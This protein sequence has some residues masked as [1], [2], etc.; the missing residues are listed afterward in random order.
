M[1][2]LKVGILEY[3]CGNIRSILS[4]IKFLGVKEI[5]LAKSDQDIFSCDCLILPGVGAFGYAIDKI[6]KNKL[7]VPIR[8]FVE[9]GGFILGIC[10]GMQL[11]FEISYEM[12][13][14]EGLGLI[15]GKIIKLKQSN[16][17]KCKLPNIGWNNITVQKNIY[18]PNNIIYRKDLDYLYF[19]HSYAALPSYKKNIIATSQFYDISFAAVVQ[20]NNIYGCQ[21]HPEKSGESGLKILHNFLKVVISK[22]RLA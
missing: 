19:V 4:A 15:P 6:N 20:K 3:G 21:F 12:G 9:K 18:Q 16:L 11:L 1:I 14:H 7:S 22:K 13:N 5:I 17:D 2:N 10:L 8:V